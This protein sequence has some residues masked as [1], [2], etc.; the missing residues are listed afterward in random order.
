M[1]TLT[2]LQAQFQSFLFGKDRD[3]ERLT[4][5]TDRLP[6][7]DRLA[8]YANAYRLRLLEILEGDFPGLKSML[9]EDGF[10]RLGSAYIDAHPSTHPSIRWFGRYLRGFLRGAAVYR[11]QPALAEMAAFEWTQ[12]EVM[13][14]ADNPL[15]GV[16]ELGAVPPEAWPGMR[17][18]FQN[19][20][21]RLDL[22]W[23]VI[24]VWQTIRDNDAK[25]PLKQAGRPIAWLLWRK[26]LDVHWRSLDEDERYAIDAARE[27]ATFAEICEGLSHTGDDQV[28]LR[29]AGFLKRWAADDL[30]AGI[31]LQVIPSESAT[32]GNRD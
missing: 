24:S 20:L 9:G 7:D 30:V 25:L 23:N 29:A 26:G 28:P 17:F 18:S 27:G 4:V 19:A 15:V 31:E 12:G 22:E 13:D 32:A 3:V 14:A 8:V 10:K 21:R 16:E 11:N 2:E 6:V 5:G 1:T